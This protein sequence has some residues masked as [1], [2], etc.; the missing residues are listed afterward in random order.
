MTYIDGFVLG[1]AE[2]DRDKFIEHAQIVDAIFIAHGALRVV[3]AWEDDV[4]D[5]TQTDFRRAVAAKPGERIVFAWIE[6]P[7]K[8]VRDEAMPKAMADPRMTAAP[9]MPF[10]GKRM[11][12]GGFTPVVE[13][14]A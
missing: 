7:S 11:I 6:W 10:D 9:A 4:A 12:F 5:G 14:G 1:V 8:A 13:L 2:A 3:E